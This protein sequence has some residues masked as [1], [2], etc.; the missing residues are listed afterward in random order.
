MRKFVFVM[1]GLLAL[2]ASTALAQDAVPNSDLDPRSLLHKAAS[3]DA[4]AAYMLG[5]YYQTGSGG[6][7]QNYDQ[8]LEWYKMSAKQAYVPAEVNLA[9]MLAQGLGTER[10][11]ATAARWYYSA[12]LT[13]QPTAENALANLY[14]AGDG[15]TKDLKKAFEYYTR[16]Q[17]HGSVEAAKHLGDMYLNGEAYDDK[18]AK[19]P[20]SDT[21]AL[22][23]YLFAAKRGNAGAQRQIAELEKQG[24]AGSMKGGMG[25]LY[26]S[27]ASK[28]DANAQYNLG[29]M[30]ETGEGDIPKDMGVALKWYRRAANQGQAEA[31][32]ALGHA[33]FEGKGIAQDYPTAWFWFSL[34]ASSSNKEGFGSDR[35]LAALKLT[36]DQITAGQAQIQAFKAQ[37]ESAGQP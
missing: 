34:A 16:A 37:A 3:G 33:Y 29:H 11:T 2:N 31:Q 23:W 5:Y 4:S 14:Y 1:L 20:A 28:G 18:G 27:A 9:N 36:P 13:G 15:V 24:R 21:D 6:V 19:L 22:K 25:E 30:Y 35:D 8:A 7:K 17:K 32:N 26:K 12:T 10:D